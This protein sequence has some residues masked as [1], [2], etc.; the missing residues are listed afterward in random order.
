MSDDTPNVLG[1][2]FI[3]DKVKV[4]AAIWYNDDSDSIGVGIVNKLNPIEL[5]ACW[6]AFVSANDSAPSEQ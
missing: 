1:P 2:G 5:D 4:I 6:Q 3:P